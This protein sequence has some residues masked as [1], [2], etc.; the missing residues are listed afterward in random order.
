MIS[1]LLAVIALEHAGLPLAPVIPESAWAD[2]GG[3][4]FRR[5]NAAAPPFIN[6]VFHDAIM[7]G[8]LIPK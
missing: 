3:L 5:S 8:F 6:A 2:S 7:G 4:P 1:V